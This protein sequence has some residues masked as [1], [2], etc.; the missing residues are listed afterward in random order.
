MRE[1][2]CH[3]I[4]ETVH[5]LMETLTATGEQAKTDTISIVNYMMSY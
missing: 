2:L 5:L 3:R 4:Q 1:C